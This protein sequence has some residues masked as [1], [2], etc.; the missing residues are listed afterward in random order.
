MKKSA[1]I[2][3]L[4]FLI[5]CIN[6]KAQDT[7]IYKNSNEIV[8]LGNKLSI[9]E[10]TFNRISF[11]D[12]MQSKEFKP[13]KKDVPNMQVSASS[14]WIRFTIINETEKSRLCLKLAYP[15]I[16]SVFLYAEDTNGNF[17]KRVTGEFVPYY[18]REHKHQNYIFDIKVPNGKPQTY[19][20]KVNASEQYQ[21]PLS[22]GTIKNIDESIFDE[23][24][25]F[26]I[27]FGIVFVMFFYN[28]F[29]FFRR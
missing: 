15:T 11:E 9:L 7:I 1:L 28:L 29:F 19:Y 2:V 22:L 8:L 13:S 26:G 10:D 18:K 17:S 25:I 3:N 16:D 24:P 20:M 27:Y 12:V 5:L 14:F 4:I 21:L 6:A 23:D